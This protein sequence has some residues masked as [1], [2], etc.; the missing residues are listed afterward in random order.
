MR[1]LWRGLAATGLAIGLMLLAAWAF[2]AGGDALGA[3]LAVVGII[4][5]VFALCWLAVA[6]DRSFRGTG[7]VIT[8]GLLAT[9]FYYGVGVISARDVAAV[10]WGT[11][12]DAVVGHTW[13]A[14]TGRKKGYHCSLEHRDGTPFPRDLGSSCKGY[15]TGDTIGIVADAHNRFAPVLG[16]RNDL[17]VTAEAIATGIGGGVLLLMIWLAAYFGRPGP[18]STKRPAGRSGNPAKR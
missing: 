14:G 9:I 5:T 10:E 7:A 11:D 2:I 1:V 13:T 15:D 6:G 16:R 3:I 12:T 17:P 4:A 8:V 18:S